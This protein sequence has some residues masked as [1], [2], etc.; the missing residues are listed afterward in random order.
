MSSQSDIP[1]IPTTNIILAD[2]LS[3]KADALRRAGKFVEAREQDLLEANNRYLE[4]ARKAE[5]QAKLL[6]EIAVALVARARLPGAR[7]RSKYVTIPAEIFHA[8]VKVVH[9]T[10]D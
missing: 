5:A 6:R 8:A 7:T 1:Q 2:Q 4:R 10:V 9:D 3:T